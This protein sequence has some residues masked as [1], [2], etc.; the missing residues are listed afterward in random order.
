MP[1]TNVPVRWQIAADESETGC[2]G[3]DGGDAEFSTLCSRRR[4][5]AEAWSM[6]LVPIPVG[7]SARSGAPAQL[8]LDEHV[9]QLKFAFASCQDYGFNTQP[10][11]T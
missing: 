9:E 6:V 4:S 8:G 7:E 3:R 5:W 11:D 1:D 10:T 2:Q